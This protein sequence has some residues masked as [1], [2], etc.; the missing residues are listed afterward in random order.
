[1]DNEDIILAAQRP[2]KLQ[3]VFRKVDPLAL[4]GSEGQKVGTSLMLNPITAGF[5]NTKVDQDY[6]VC[7]KSKC[8]NFPVRELKFKS[9]SQRADDLY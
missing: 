4:E 7:S 3:K 5:R 6:E 1:M 8:C 9:C 2:W